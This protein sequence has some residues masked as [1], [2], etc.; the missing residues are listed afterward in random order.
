MRGRAIGIVTMILLA[1][2]PATAACLGDCSGAGT[3]AVADLIRG[4]NI[5]LGNAAVGTCDAFDGDGDG[6]VTIAEL[7]VAVGNA[8]DGCRDGN[9]TATVGPATPSPTA[10]A[11]AAGPCG[12]TTSVDAFFATNRGR[13]LRVYRDG[14]RGHLFDQ[15]SDPAGYQVLFLSGAIGNG[16]NVRSDAIPTLAILPFSAEDQLDDQ[17]HEV[18]VLFN[19]DPAQ[20]RVGFL[21]ILQCDKAT[22]DW[23]FQLTS[24]NEPL[25][26]FVTFT[27]VAAR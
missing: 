9:P 27:S 24:A 4:V 21:G 13:M 16:I 23:F 18:N 8:L 20:P 12:D 11:V 14:G 15:Y 2:A 5:A 6:A 1:G 7:V 19:A 3:V 22:G 10:T 17:P 25:T 26:A